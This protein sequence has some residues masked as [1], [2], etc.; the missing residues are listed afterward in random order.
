MTIRAFENDESAFAQGT[1]L[2]WYG[3]IGNIPR[4]WLI[5]NGTNGTNHMTN[6]FLQGATSDSQVGNKESSNVKALSY[7]QM[8]RHRHFA[9]TST[10]G[11]HRHKEKCGGAASSNDGGVVY[12]VSS[13]ARDNTTL[14]TSYNGSHNHDVDFNYK[15]SGTFMDWEPPYVTVMYIEKA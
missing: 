13:D 10:D 4:G 15:G 14:R 5:A 2:M 12:L 11:N 7:A 1:L 3:H 6:T 9:E 8:P